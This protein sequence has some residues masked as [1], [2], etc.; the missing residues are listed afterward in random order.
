MARK[1]EIRETPNATKWRL[2][3]LTEQY[4]GL[5]YSVETV[6]EIVGTSV[7]YVQWVEN[8]AYHE[9]IP[10]ALRQIGSWCL[11]MLRSFFGHQRDESVTMDMHTCDLCGKRVPSPRHRV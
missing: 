1:H 11:D 2:Y 6:A 4:L 5:G 7:E 9:D 3:R 10:S 8:F